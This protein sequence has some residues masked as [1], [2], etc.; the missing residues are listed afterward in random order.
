M[1]MATIPDKSPLTLRC[2]ITLDYLLYLFVGS[3]SKTLK[4]MALRKALNYV[5]RGL[6]AF[7]SP[8]SLQG[9]R[10]LACC[11]CEMDGVRVQG[12]SKNFL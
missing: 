4:G 6:Q 11:R 8:S 9:G 5:L 10:S 3:C 1:V 2:G 12:L 7:M